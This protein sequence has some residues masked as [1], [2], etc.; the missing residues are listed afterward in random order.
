MNGV[1]TKQTTLAIIRNFF[2]GE[3]QKEISEVDDHVPFRIM[4]IFLRK[5]YES[6]KSFLDIIRFSSKGTF[7]HKERR[8][9][10]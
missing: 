5:Y 4:D 10:E 9:S 8:K 2:Y 3:L 1:I 6:P 7:N